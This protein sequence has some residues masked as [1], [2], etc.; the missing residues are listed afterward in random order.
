MFNSLLQ[1]EWATWLRNTAVGNILRNFFVLVEIA[2]L[3]EIS[4]RLLLFG[5]K[6]KAT[7]EIKQ[8]YWKTAIVCLFVCLWL[9]YL[10]PQQDL[11]G[12]RSWKVSTPT[13]LGL[14]FRF[15]RLPK[16][17]Q[18][19]HPRAGQGMEILLQRE[20]QQQKSYIFFQTGTKSN[21]KTFKYSAK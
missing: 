16:S 21:I 4:K 18:S 5:K 15:Y 19:D 11:E 12:W 13:L 7:L 20:F 10:A 1:L 9:T 2:N 6:K 8:I 3:S 14:K 17:W